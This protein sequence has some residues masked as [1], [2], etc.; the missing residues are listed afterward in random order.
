[1]IHWPDKKTP[2]YTDLIE[3]L[4]PAILWA[5]GVDSGIITKDFDYTGYDTPATAHICVAPTDALTIAY[6]EHSAQS[7]LETVV[8]II[9]RLGYEQGKREDRQVVAMLDKLERLQEGEKKCTN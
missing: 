6:H 1:M 2:A 9:F 8:N 5:I 7:A 3:P 4:L